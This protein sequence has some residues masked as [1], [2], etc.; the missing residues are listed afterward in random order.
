MTPAGNAGLGEPQPFL[1][2]L[3][4]FDSFR[5]TLLHLVSLAA[6]FSTPS[7]TR[8][9]C[10]LDTLLFRQAD[11]R[12][13]FA[14][15][16]TLRAAYSLSIP[17]QLHISP[18]PWAGSGR[19][20]RYPGWKPVAERL[21][22]T[23]LLTTRLEHD[24]MV[25]TQEPTAEDHVPSCLSTSRLFIFVARSGRAFSLRPIFLQPWVDRTDH[26]VPPLPTIP[27]CLS[28]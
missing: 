22:T 10:Y 26:M 14:A 5:A 2:D 12:H 23:Y 4:L 16:R 21:F 19:W 25:S 6:F 17:L 9:P 3:Y 11:T 1:P 20:L 28:Y 18:R 27:A 8:T 24:W 7:L 13:D 15:P